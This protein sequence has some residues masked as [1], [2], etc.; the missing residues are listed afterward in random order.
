[1]KPKKVAFVVWAQTPTIT[2]HLMTVA[3]VIFLIGLVSLCS[4]AGHAEKRQRQSQ[5]FSPRVSPDGRRIAFVARMA[6]G[7]S[8]LYIIDADGKNL[9][10]LTNGYGNMQAWS[11]DGS[12]LIF[13]R[14]N[15][16]TD[17]QSLVVIN[18]DGTGER[19]INTG[20]K[21]NQFPSF[22]PDAKQIVLNLDGEIGF[23]VFT[24]N[25]DGSNPRKITPGMQPAWSPNRK[26]IAFATAAANSGP[27]RI[28]VLNPDGTQKRQVSTGD[29]AHECPTWSAD[30][31]RIAYFASS[32]DKAS[33]KSNAV[34]RVVNVDGSGD[35]EIGTH[36][37]PYLDEMPS[38][39]PD[40]KRLAIQSNRDGIMRIYIIDLNG[41]TLA[42]VTP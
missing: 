28:F 3:I 15:N 40:G 35:A 32:R 41:Q 10:R 39:F 30:S 42:C 6:D 26:H 22:S 34:I 29:G 38:W 24:I 21:K 1:M 5:A 12:K 33:G 23:G 31:K 17:T 7:N 8:G 25:A 2:I 11:P 20:Q 27:P 14:I 37:N 36:S 19:V 4:S 18:A 9:R 16:D 13:A